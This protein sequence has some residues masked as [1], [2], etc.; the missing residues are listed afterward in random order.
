MEHRE[1]VT[2]SRIGSDRELVLVAAAK[3]TAAVG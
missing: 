2:L 3:S 1:V